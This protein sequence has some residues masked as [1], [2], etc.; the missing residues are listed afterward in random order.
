MAKRLLPN[1]VKFIVTSEVDGNVDCVLI[2]T[3]TLTV[4]AST[5]GCG[6]VSTTLAVT[7]GVSTT[8]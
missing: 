8:G 6:G 7:A 5:I 1:S 2:A 4:G 3:L